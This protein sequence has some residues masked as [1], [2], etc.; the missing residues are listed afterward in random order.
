LRQ[1][2]PWQAILAAGCKAGSADVGR[3]ERLCP[4]RGEA[5]VAAPEIEERLAVEDFGTLDFAEEDGV[6]AGDVGGNYVTREVDE[7]AFQER[8]AGFSPAIVDAELRF[9]GQFFFPLGEIDGDGL[10][11]VFQNVYA[12]AV[13]LQDHRQELGTLID[14]N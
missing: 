6:I 12:K 1:D 10:L 2:A 7:G 14:A 8:D 11:V 9:D 5:A 4:L 3:P 13:L